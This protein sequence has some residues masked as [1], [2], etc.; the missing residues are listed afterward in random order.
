MNVAMLAKWIMYAWA[1]GRTVSLILDGN[2]ATL[3]FRDTRP[4][5]G[6]SP[7][8]LNDADIKEAVDGSKSAEDGVPFVYTDANIDPGILHLAEI[9]LVIHCGGHDL[10]TDST[11]MNIRLCDVS[12]QGFG[13][14]H[15]EALVR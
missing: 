3:R 12:F 1:K 2:P 5:I 9:E 6:V 10:C 11:E 15:S 4:V 8:W 7:D 14:F 13:T